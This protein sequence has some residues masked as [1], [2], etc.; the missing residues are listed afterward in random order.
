MLVFKA[1][2]QKGLLEH[3]LAKGAFVPGDIAF[4]FKDIVEATGMTEPETIMIFWNGV[5][6]LVDYP[7]VRNAW[8]REQAL[9]RHS[10]HYTKGAAFI[11]TVITLSQCSALA[12]EAVQFMKRVKMVGSDPLVEESLNEPLND[13]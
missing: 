10:E 3:L 1:H 7:T 13:H 8:L 6:Y 11:P 4:T 12:D 2:D 9:A 5:H